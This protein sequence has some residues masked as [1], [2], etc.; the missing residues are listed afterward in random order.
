[1]SR[2]I[3][4][5]LGGLCAIVL[6]L[7]GLT[8]TTVATASPSQHAASA[9]EAAIWLAEQ[10]STDGTFP[11]PDAPRPDHGLMIDALFAMHAA[12]RPDLAEPIVDALGRS[13]DSG[14]VGYWRIEADGYVETIVGAL[15][16]STLAIQVAGRDARSFAGVDHLAALRDSVASDGDQEGLLHG[17]VVNGDQ[18]THPLGNVFDHALGIMSL[19]A[20]GELPDTTIPA[21]I[22]TFQCEDGA[23]AMTKGNCASGGAD[24]AAM[25][26]SALLTARDHGAREVDDAIDRTR[27]WLREHQHAA[28]GWGGGT[29]TTETNT[30]ST[31][32]AAQ[33]LGHARGSRGA[34]EKGAT[35]ITTAQATAERDGDGPFAAHI[36]AIAYM[37]REYQDS[38]RGKELVGGTDRWVR[39]TAQAT[40]G[41]AQVSFSDLIDGRLPTAPEPWPRPKPSTPSPSPT[42]P[43]PAPPGAGGDRSGHSPSPAAGHPAPPAGSAPDARRVVAPA[44]PAELEEASDSPAGRAAAYLAGNLVD[45]DHIEVT[46]GEQTYV[47]YDATAGL[48]LALH[49]AGEQGEARDRAAAFLLDPGSIDAYVHGRPYEEGDAVYAEPLAKVILVELLQRGVHGADEHHDALITDWIEVLGGDLVEDGAVRDTGDFGVRNGDTAQ[50][51]WTTLALAAAGDTGADELAEQLTTAQC[52]DGLFGTRI[53][54]DCRKGE[55]PITDIAA[56]ALNGV[57]QQE[58]TLTSSASD[59]TTIRPVLSADRGTSVAALRTSIDQAAPD[60]VVRTADEHLDSVSTADVATTRLALGADVSLATLALTQVQREDGGVA[61]DVDAEASDFFMS[62][63]TAPALAGRTWLQTPE[64]PL[65]PA[66]V[67]YVAPDVTPVAAPEPAQGVNPWMAAAMMLLSAAVAGYAGHGLSRRPDKGSVSSPG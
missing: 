42:A 41:L 24:G 38:R 22:A 61:L 29:G 64:S 39:A 56:Q 57:G 33:A 32:L 59:T 18:T 2:R 51:A 8:T 52:A 4:L 3:R 27:G 36:G 13:G 31:G 49:A 43:A 14:A 25:A 9:Q 47:D 54:G 11:N 65:R 50:H 10:L 17:T 58:V 46:D 67:T 34:V 62:L 6:A 20:A 5:A 63:R 19:A 35:Y 7:G 15:A 66:P 1:M 21:F 16:K 37:P 55:L 40:L 53:G 45:G 12:G 48:V 44:D 23:W 26:L 28:G 60:G 30:N